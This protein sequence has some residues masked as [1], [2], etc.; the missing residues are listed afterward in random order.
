MDLL[1]E[2]EGKMSYRYPNGNVFYRKLD[3]DLPVC[4]KGE[5]IYLYDQ[6]GKKYIDGSGGPLCV[7]IGHGVAEIGE[8]IREQ[9]Q[10]VAYVHGSQFTTVPIEE[11]TSKLAKKLPQGIDKI[12]IVGSGSEANEAALKLA[13]QY[14]L[15]I[16]N[17]QRYRVIGRWFSYHGS[18]LGALSMM[19]KTG[20]RKPFLPLVLDFPHIPAPYCY[21][22]P[23][24]KKYPECK[25]LCARALEKTIQLEGPETISAFIAEPVIGSTLGAVIPPKEYYQIIR[26]ICD[27]YNILFIADEVMSG[28]GRTGKWFA[29][30]H[31]G[32]TPDIVTLGKGI[33]SGYVPL[34]AMATKKEI[35]DIIKEKSGKFVHG[36]TFSHHAVSSAVGL[37]V[38]NYMEKHNLV[39]NSAKRGQY[40]INKLKELSEFSFVGDIRGKGL[41]VGI[42]F[43]KDK[44]SKIPFPRKFA[45]VEKIVKKSF[46]KGL[47]I[48]SSTV[49]TVDGTNG[50]GIV[51]AP[52]FVIKENEI[53]EIVDILRKVFKEME[54]EL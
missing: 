23:Y 4:V 11:F 36:H 49:G 48:Y 25:L 42:E 35:V 22:C 1:I 2:M 24:E 16:G 5:G 30:E 53:D 41:M 7:I 10:K 9:A 26:E 44:D 54:K 38:L 14:Q 28:Y 12:Y 43:V 13:R 29:L 18:T 19:G 20:F 40:L 34:A 33:S 27:K 37:A 50:E 45:F 17:S 6:E 32:V 3:T 39:E 8:A 52:P 47:Y 15:S 31:W 51:I 46:E 21:R